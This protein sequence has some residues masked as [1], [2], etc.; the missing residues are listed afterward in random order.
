MAFGILVVAG[1]VTM[2]LAVEA[3]GGQNLVINGDFEKGNTGFTTGY[4]LGDVSNP[5]GYSISPRPAT[6]PGAFADWCNCGDHT[7]AT[8]KMM[9]VNG[10]TTPGVTVWEET[11]KSR[12]PRSIAFHTGEPRWITTALRF[13]ICWRRLTAR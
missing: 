10:A 8:G 9:V 5:G 4:T 11:Y 7:T 13:P 3:Q 2:A 1:L 6:A 12:R